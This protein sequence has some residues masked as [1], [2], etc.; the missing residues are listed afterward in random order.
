MKASLKTTIVFGIMF[1]CSFL[2]FSQN[3][4]SFHKK[5]VIILDIQKEYTE[6][7]MLD[8]F[9]QKLID[10]INF[11]IEN[12]DADRII[13]VKSF[14]KLLNL[15]F[16]FP[17]IYVSIDTSA[18]WDLDS[19]MNLVNENIISKE[20]SNVFKVKEL[21]N[22]LDQNN[23]K[24]I[25]V[26]GLMAEQCVYKSLLGGKELGYKMF[27]IPSAIAWESQ[28]NKEKTINALKLKGITFM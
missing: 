4:N 27:T 1:F 7:S 19:R 15:S 23:A 14:H 12:T 6:N 10:S 16:S 18:K 22:Y 17:P 25:I 21:T 13:Y 28:K 20:E 26:I 24:E 11:V 8:S 5:Y 2:G 3:S 9:S